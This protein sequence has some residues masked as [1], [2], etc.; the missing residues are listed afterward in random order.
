[1]E[2]VATRK[3]GRVAAN[4]IELAYETFGDPGAP[5]VVLIMGLATQMIAWPDELCA[6]LA[7]RGLFVVRFDNRDVGGSTHLRNLPPPRLA[8]IVVRRRPP[9][10]SIGDMA[11]D[12]AGLI[13]GLGLGAVHLVGTSVGGFIAQAVALE[14]ADRVRTLT[15]IMTSTG[16]RRVGQ[17]KPRVYA[18]LLRQRVST[19]RPAAMS[20]AVE[21]FR[22][23]GS[24]G[25]AFDEEY[26][27]DL[28]GA[29]TAGTTRPVSGGSSQRARASQTAPRRCAAS[30]SR[31]W[32]STGCMTRWSRR[33][34][35]WRSP[36][37]SRTPGS[38]G[39][40]A[41]A[42]TCPGTVAGVR[43][44]DRGADRAGRTAPAPGAASG[45]AGG[46]VHRDRWPAT[47]P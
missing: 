43:Q 29:G 27:C 7:R 10:Y 45:L 3:L 31:H 44:A 36:G 38:R 34:G 42:T 39:S 19:G 21:T 13:D 11:A 46:R 24:H 18:R 41:W 9:P 8:D 32:S 12:V 28:A 5:P 4:G 15:L 6:G 20:A 47:A 25:F 2:E 14:H 35:A 40:P 16:S 37:R 1:M 17:P 22:L 30:R 33:A 23:I 26:V